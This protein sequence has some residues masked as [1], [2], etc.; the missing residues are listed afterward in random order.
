M[1]LLMI[2]CVGLVDIEAWELRRCVNFCGSLKSIDHLD[3][4]IDGS[5][6]CV[7]IDGRS[8]NVDFMT[9]SDI[10]SK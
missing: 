8:K 1:V 9:D 5:T 2:G 3:L 7:C 6:T 10:R 4:S